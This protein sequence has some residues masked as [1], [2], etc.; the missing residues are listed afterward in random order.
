MPG[1]YTMFEVEI[2][3]DITRDGIRCASFRTCDAVCSEQIDIE[4]EEDIIRDVRFTRG[5]QGNTRGI[6]ALCAGM[7]KDEVI[8][9]LEGINCKGRGTSCP[10]QLAQALK[11]L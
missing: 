11:E 7:R 10:D 2:L 4:L 5:C 1:R 8:A 3:S 6:S 9:R